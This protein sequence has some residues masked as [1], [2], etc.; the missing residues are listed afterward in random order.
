MYFIF[1]Y[2]LQIDIHNLHMIIKLNAHMTQSLSLTNNNFAYF[3]Y[4]YIYMYML[5]FEPQ[6]LDLINS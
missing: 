3:L 1:Q 5:N 2:I 4:K 6:D